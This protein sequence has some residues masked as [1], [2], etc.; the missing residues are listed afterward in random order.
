MSIKPHVQH[1]IALV[2]QGRMIEAIQTYYGDDVAMQENLN[3]PTVGLAANIQR[4]RAFYG[5]L[6]SARFRA[7]SVLV[8]GN[9][10]AINWIFD[11]TTAD[12]QRYQMDEIAYQT[13]R[14]GQ[15]VH[16]RYIYDTATLAAA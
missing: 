16:E 4:E 14:N 9:H 1:L 7:V 13:W 3:D 5:S 6:Q 2:E 10:A 12:G 11:Y 15:I 8:E